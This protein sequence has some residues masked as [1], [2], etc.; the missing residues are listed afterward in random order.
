MAGFSHADVLSTVNCQLL[1]ADCQL[2]TALLP[3]IV[4]PQPLLVA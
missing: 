1:T 4:T 2:P 3:F